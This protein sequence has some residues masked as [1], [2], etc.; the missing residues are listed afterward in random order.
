MIEN[1]YSVNVA[2]SYGSHYCRVKLPSNLTRKE[3]IERA[4]LIARKFGDEFKVSM[5][6]VECSGHEVE[7]T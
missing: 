6:Y 4:Q 5:T 7:I 2:T 3:A 1:H